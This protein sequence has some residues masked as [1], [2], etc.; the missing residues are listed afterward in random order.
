MDCCCIFHCALAADAW[1]EVLGLNYTIFAE[2]MTSQEAADACLSVGAELASF[3]SA[4]EL[5]VCAAGTVSQHVHACWESHLVS[6][7]AGTDC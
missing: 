2:P 4:E 6:P 5:E 1:V 3:R 7:S